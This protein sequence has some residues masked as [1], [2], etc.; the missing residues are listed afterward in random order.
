MKLSP[1]CIYLTCLSLIVVNCSTDPNQFNF[2]Q[3]LLEGIDFEENTPSDVITNDT[4]P[5]DTTL[6]DATQKD[7]IPG[8]DTLPEEITVSKTCFIHDDN[9][10]GLWTFDEADGLIANNRVRN[11]DTLSFEKTSQKF[12]TDFGRAAIFN[13]NSASM[14]NAQNYFPG[15][16]TVEARVKM[17]V[18]PSENTSPRPHSMIVSTADWTSSNAKGYELRITDTDGKAEFII[19]T[20]DGWVSA[21]STMTLETEK[22]YKIAGQYDG[23]YITVFIDGMLSG[24]TVCT[25]PLNPSTTGFGVGRRI[26]DQPFYFYGAIDEVAISNV[27]R[28]NYTSDNWY[29]TDHHT[30]AHWTFDDLDENLIPDISGNYHTAQCIGTP[31]SVTAVAGNALNFHSYYCKTATSSVFYPQHLTVEA[32]VKLND[33]PPSN[34]SPRPH[35]MIVSTINWSGNNCS[36]YE[37]R[38]SGTVGKVEFIIGDHTGWHYAVSEKTLPLNEW[39]SLAGQY[40]GKTI[41]VYVDSELWAQTQ[42]EGTIQQCGI[43]I[44][45]ASRLVDQ[46]FYINGNIDEISISG[47]IRY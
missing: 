18:K 31:V 24:K 23:A 45:I 19:G 47:T 30:I 36:G 20:A 17:D 32:A 9:T 3:N 35:M 15:I 5:N 26:V 41:S 38:I 1:V 2:F 16:I 8:D 13:N 40:D 25:K 34:M 4:L 37:L 6:E 14:N 12:D 22:W 27:R 33:Y 28:Y 21:I 44:G 43:D 7:T 42:Y 46:P 39:H 29:T 10:A 11:R